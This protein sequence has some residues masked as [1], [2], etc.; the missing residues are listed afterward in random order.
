MIQKI[1]PSLDPLIHSASVRLAGFMFFGAIVLSPAPVLP[2]Q[3][4]QYFANSTLP[5]SI[6]CGDE[7]T[8]AFIFFA[9]AGTAFGPVGAGVCASTLDA[10]TT[11]HNSATHA[12]TPDTPR[13]RT[14]SL[15]MELRQIVY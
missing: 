2:W 11:A 15:F 1:S 10:V 7:A 14:I 12:N 4:R 8:A 13:I 6:A 3:K 9:S 5:A